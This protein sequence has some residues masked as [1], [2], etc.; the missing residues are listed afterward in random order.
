MGEFDE[1][2][3]IDTDRRIRK[4]DDSFDDLGRWIDERGYVRLPSDAFEDLWFV[5]VNG[6]LHDGQGVNTT[7]KLG[8]PSDWSVALPP[9][10]ETVQWEDEAIARRAGLS[11]TEPK[12][13]TPEDVERFQAGIVKS[14]RGTDDRGQ[15]LTWANNAD[16]AAATDLHG[17]TL[18]PEYVGEDQR[19]AAFAADTL[20]A[21]VDPG[22]TGNSQWTTTYDRADTDSVAETRVDNQLLCDESGTP[23]TG[24]FG[25]VVDPGSGKLYTF[26]RSEG[27][28]S[29]SGAWLSLDGL[30]R[31][32]LIGMIQQ[33]LQAGEQ[34]SYVHHSTALAGAPVAGAGTLTV[35][36]GK[37][38][39]IDD[40]SGHYK[41]E[42][43]Y[44]WQTVSWL[45]AQG[46]PVDQIKVRM[47]AKDR[48]PEKVLEGWKML[49]SG[50]NQTQ[51]RLKDELNSEIIRAGFER[52]RQA[53]AARAVPTTPAGVHQQRTGCADYN[54]SSDGTYCMSCDTDL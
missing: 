54:P 27:Y 46:M 17:R 15:D 3:Y 11:D 38:T 49:Q 36:A 43:E 31:G 39:K 10:D 40:D 22:N 52:E 14:A 37:I 32:Q 41:P 26:N 20:R 51:A 33:A 29:K 24:S 47:I 30:D 9:A 2:A 42:G 19:S 18:E 34:V 4:A 53:N 16:I 48:E 5:D 13:H 50:G 23:L 44:L 25:Y 8:V 12:H 35:Q 45:Q 28:V 6:L 21:K 7:L 1:G